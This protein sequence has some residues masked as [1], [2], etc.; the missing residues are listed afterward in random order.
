MKFRAMLRGR[1][2][3]AGCQTSYHTYSL[4]INPTNT[5][6]E[7]LQFLMDGIAESTITEAS[8]STTAWQEAIDHGFL[9]CGPRG[10]ALMSSALAQ[11]AA[12]TWTGIPATAPRRRPGPMSPTGSWSIRMP[13]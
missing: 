12:P 5:S 7:T 6:A 3:W 9:T 13:I 4:I 10:D 2:V 8:V 1:A 11:A